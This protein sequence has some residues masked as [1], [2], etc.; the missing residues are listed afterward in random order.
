MFMQRNFELMLWRKI[1]TVK[2]KNER[3]TSSAIGTLKC[4]FTNEINQ[5]ITLIRQR[6]GLHFCSNQF[7]RGYDGN[8]ST[9]KN[10]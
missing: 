8:S 7:Q 4:L 5:T 6:F 9:C 1:K 2:Q 3:R 10:G